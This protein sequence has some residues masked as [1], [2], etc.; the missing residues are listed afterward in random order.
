MVKNIHNSRRSSIYSNSN[1]SRSQSRL[2]SMSK[3]YVRYGGEYYEDP[4]YVRKNNH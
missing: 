4:K 3:K 1:Y 2:S